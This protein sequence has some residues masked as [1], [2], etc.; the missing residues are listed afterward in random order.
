MNDDSQ[1]IEKINQQEI[2]I[3]QIFRSVEKTRKY[4]L[5]MVWI[6][7]VVLVLPLIG[8]MFIVPTVIGSYTSSLEGLLE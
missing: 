8:M 3:D 7:I 5:T 2:K 6:T 1:I 4:T